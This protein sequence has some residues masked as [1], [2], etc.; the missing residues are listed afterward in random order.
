MLKLR[1]GGGA[2]IK[3]KVC[4]FRILYKVIPKRNYYGGYGYLRVLFIR[5]PYYIWDLE[6]GPSLENYPCREYNANTPERLQL[7][8][9]TPLL[10]IGTWSLKP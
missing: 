4:G 2:Y 5:V 6:R 10:S 1:V 9:P 7:I 8:L 3:F